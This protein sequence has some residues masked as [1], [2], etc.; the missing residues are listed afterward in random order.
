[1]SRQPGE[2]FM[3]MTGHVLNSCLECL[4]KPNNKTDV[5]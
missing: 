2:R 5:S 1:M 4:E 3:D